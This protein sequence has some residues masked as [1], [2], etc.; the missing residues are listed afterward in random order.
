MP[1]LYFQRFQGYT[2]TSRGIRVA[3]AQLTP[4]FRSNKGDVFGVVFTTPHSAPALTALCI[5]CILW[6]GGAADAVSLRACEKALQSTRATKLFWS[7]A[8]SVVTCFER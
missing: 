6:R 3:P 7:S 4:R 5:Y 8:R 2:S 1:R